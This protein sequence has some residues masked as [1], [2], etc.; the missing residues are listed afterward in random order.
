MPR[1]SAVLGSSA[2]RKSD[3]EDHKDE[4]LT[5]SQAAAK[6]I[7]LDD[8]KKVPGLSASTNPRTRNEIGTVHIPRSTG[9]FASGNTQT[10]FLSTANM[11]IAGQPGLLEG[12]TSMAEVNAR[13]Q[14]GNIELGHE[15]PDRNDPDPKRTHFDTIHKLDFQHKG[16][17]AYLDRDI[18]PPD[19]AVTGGIEPTLYQRRVEGIMT[20]T[21]TLKNT[22]SRDRIPAPQQFYGTKVVRPPTRRSHMSVDR[23]A[24]SFGEDV[25]L[26]LDRIDDPKIREN[27]ERNARTEYRDNF[28]SSASEQ[29]AS[30]GL[31]TDGRRKISAH[32]Q[33]AHY[34]LGTD[35]DQAFETEY[36]AANQHM[37]SSA[38]KDKL[39]N[40]KDASS[41]THGN[42]S[43]QNNQQQ[44]GN[45]TRSLSN[46][47]Q[48][49]RSHSP[50]P[51]LAAQTSTL[52]PHVSL[53]DVYP[54]PRKWIDHRDDSKA[55][56]PALEAYRAQADPGMRLAGT[57]AQPLSGPRSPAGSPRSPG[58]SLK[59][60]SLP[61]G[62]RAD[63]ANGG[64]PGVE[65]SQRSWDASLRRY[66]QS[67]RTNWSSMNNAGTFIGTGIGSGDPTAFYE[68]EDGSVS[69]PGYH[70]S[71]RR[72]GSPNSSQSSPKYL[73]DTSPAPSPSASGGTSPLSPAG[74]AR[75]RGGPI[76]VRNAA[77]P[78]ASISPNARPKQNMD[79]FFRAPQVQDLF[80]PTDRSPS[81]S[82]FPS[83][84][85]TTRWGTSVSSPHQDSVVAGTARPES[86]RTTLSIRPSSSFATSGFLSY[87]PSNLRDSLV[88]SRLQEQSEQI[89]DRYEDD[90]YGSQ[91]YQ[92]EADTQAQ[93]QRHHLNAT[94]QEIV[95]AKRNE[96]STAPPS[97][98]NSVHVSSAPPKKRLLS[99]PALRTQLGKT[100]T[101]TMNLNDQGEPV[102]V[103]ELKSRL[104]E[105]PRYA[106]GM[107]GGENENPSEML[108]RALDQERT[109]RGDFFQF[110][111]ENEA[112]SKTP[113]GKNQ[114]D[115]NVHV[116]EYV[117]GLPPAGTVPGAI[118]GGY[119]DAAT[120]GKKVHLSLGHDNT[121][122]SSTTKSS[123]IAHSA[124]EYRDNV[125]LRDN[126][127]AGKAVAGG[128]QNSLDATYK[129]RAPP[130]VDVRDGKI[131]PRSRS[132]PATAPDLAANR[133]GREAS[134]PSADV[135]LRQTSQ[136]DSMRT[137]NASEQRSIQALA[138]SRLLSASSHTNNNDRPGT[139][140]SSYSAS[141]ATN[142]QP[143]AATA[144]VFRGSPTRS[145]PEPKSPSTLVINAAKYLHPQMN[146]ELPE[147]PLHQPGQPQ[148]PSRPESRAH[149]NAAFDEANDSDLASSLRRSE[150]D[151][152]RP[153]SRLS[154]S[155][156]LS[157]SARPHIR[158]LL[159]HTD[160][161]KP[162]PKH[163]V[164]PIWTAIS[165]RGQDMGAVSGSVRC[166]GT[167]Q[168]TLH[169]IER[170]NLARCV[171]DT[172][173]RT[174]DN[175]TIIVETDDLNQYYDQ[176]TVNVVS[177]TDEPTR[178][179][180]RRGRPSYGQFSIV[181]GEFHA[182]MTA[183]GKLPLQSES[184]IDQNRTSSI[185][186][187]AGVPLGFRTNT[188]FSDLGM[189]QDADIRPGQVHRDLRPGSARARSKSQPARSTRPTELGS[190]F[191][192]VS[193]EIARRIRDDECPP[194]D[195]GTNGQT[196]TRIFAPPEERGVLPH[197]IRS[198]T[199]PGTVSAL[200]KSA[201]TAGATGY[202][203][204]RK[205]YWGSQDADYLN[206]TATSATNALTAS[207]VLGHEHLTRGHDE[208]LGRTVLEQGGRNR[209][210]IANRT[211]LPIPEQRSTFAI[212]RFEKQVIEEGF[213]SSR[214]PTMGK[215]PGPKSSI[216]FG[217]DAPIQTTESMDLMGTTANLR[218]LTSVNLGESTV[219]PGVPAMNVTSSKFDIAGQKSA[220]AKATHK[221]TNTGQLFQNNPRSEVTE[222]VMTSQSGWESGGGKTITPF[223]P[224]M[225]NI[226]DSL[227]QH[228]AIQTQK[229]W[230]NK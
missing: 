212:S 130:P 223:V 55:E 147:R 9:P 12:A 203:A 91:E 194:E 229:Q 102:P 8:Y 109:A 78:P 108:Q 218:G 176:E 220:V 195:W 98:P 62:T 189:G 160:P 28:S 118:Y 87:A 94:G 66:K 23:T 67:R 17:E 63:T 228:P 1:N 227:K 156:S 217:H 20:N 211:S 187:S 199:G 167:I 85:H 114:N 221:M 60:L 61:I 2:F 200:Q 64:A 124:N 42:P 40:S 27:A 165:P 162:K 129:K 146:A 190:E 41:R 168:G 99:S 58:S 121:P 191:P 219:V 120:F 35:N 145:Y 70:T 72:S 158:A 76:G 159:Q 10:K 39:W 112:A 154:D 69:P 90:N 57:T 113:R 143:A 169:G 13:I 74:A 88:P 171:S 116:T 128:I 127:A 37:F 105:G 45:S 208:K 174:A 185:K 172:L 82:N 92:Y 192:H 11:P 29:L 215:R 25:D 164:S 155:R 24:V 71:T 47:R 173:R 161:K 131:L 31:G 21:S 103:P 125:N 204:G 73:Y 136:F 151:T 36:T 141:S 38:A 119:Q 206:S 15:I 207:L 56:V 53:A 184:D 49:G 166:D 51:T 83:P 123:F 46:S 100:K 115:K 6:N 178:F 80:P 209:A 126:S 134:Y 144:H 226:M 32:I 132:T 106:P 180:I 79:S 22:A 110:T 137:K 89:D 177:R 33:S 84:T 93:S 59:P 95:F 96:Q 139:T 138:N 19:S 77:I 101:S 193:E 133:T 34:T 97:S 222:R 54:K 52:S 230:L 153:N 50:D 198:Q 30:P 163:Y 213:Q 186:V 149:P 179:L 182:A 107:G 43:Q 5:S 3:R 210:E 111:S 16:K 170:R 68:N 104:F 75:G 86:Q 197:T 216:V 26:E 152:V 44:L 48:L 196:H 181:S 214:N 18:I 183:D 224:V 225:N 201:H 150:A 81:S 140:Q 205:D 142:W 65:D 202:E 135:V 7:P 188:D 4:W 117:P 14:S 175:R 157:P 148:P 122:L